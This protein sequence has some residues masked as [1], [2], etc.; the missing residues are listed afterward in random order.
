MFSIMILNNNISIIHSIKKMN[1]KSEL[2]KKILDTNVLPSDLICDIINYA[3]IN[4]EYKANLFLDKL[5]ITNKTWYFDTYDKYQLDLHPMVYCFIHWFNATDTKFYEILK[6]ELND[7]IQALYTNNTSSTEFAIL[8]RY[9]ESKGY[10]RIE[11]RAY[12]DIAEKLW[13]DD[14]YSIK[15]GNNCSN[16]E[17]DN[18]NDGSSDGDGANFGYDTSDDDITNEVREAREASE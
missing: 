16:N 8:R 5:G 11:C 9:L 13:E 2:Y 7:E 14:S 18:V 12:S 10:G 15:Y 17:A 3:S 1:L 4:H 6:I